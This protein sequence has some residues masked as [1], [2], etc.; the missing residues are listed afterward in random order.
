MYLYKNTALPLYFGF[1][2]NIVSL[3]G[4][5]YID[6]S[7]IWLL[8]AGRVEEA[9]EVLRRVYAI[10][11]FS[12]QEPLLENNFIEN[13]FKTFGGSSTAEKDLPGTLS[14]LKDTTVTVNLVIMVY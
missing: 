5:I 1:I 14:Y 6:E 10:N 2:F 12:K 7:P 13:A 9:R 3:A 8:R 4:L 11:G